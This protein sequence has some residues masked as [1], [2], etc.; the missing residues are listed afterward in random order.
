MDRDQAEKFREF[1]EAIS[2]TGFDVKSHLSEEGVAM[3]RE[4]EDRHMESLSDGLIRRFAYMQT[5][6]LSQS[7][8][9]ID[10]LRSLMPKLTLDQKINRFIAFA[11]TNARI[12]AARKIA[13]SDWPEDF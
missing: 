8:D 1:A 4:A 7:R 10:H 2:A 9:W 3:L 13:G 6:R 5:E 11:M 12:N